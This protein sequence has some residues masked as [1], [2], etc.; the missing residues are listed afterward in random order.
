MRLLRTLC[1]EGSLEN[2]ERQ[3]EKNAEEWVLD[4]R[5][6]ILPMMTAPEPVHNYHGEKWHQ[7][8]MFGFRRHESPHMGDTDGNE[9]RR[10]HSQLFVEVRALHFD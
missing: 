10:H 5:A 6:I 8:L 3:F 1:I 2:P 4:G 9:P 7:R